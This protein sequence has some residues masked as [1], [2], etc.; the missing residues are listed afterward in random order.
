[1]SDVLYLFKAGHFAGRCI[2][3]I[4]RGCL[5]QEDSQWKAE[6]SGLCIQEAHPAET[7][8]VNIEREMLVVAWGCIK[9][10]YLLYGRKFV[11]QSDHK[12]LEDKHLKY[13]NDATSQA[14]ET[15][16]EITMICFYC[17][18]CSRFPG[19]SCRCIKQS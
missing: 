18:V 6:T 1:M 7:R 2:Q 9:F 14:T 8:Y 15:T 19:S 5:L 4:S 13:L 3:V 16:A 12:P 11:C 10:Y 17:K